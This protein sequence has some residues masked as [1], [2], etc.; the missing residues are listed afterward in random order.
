MSISETRPTIRNCPRCG[1][2]FPCR[3]VGLICDPC[4]AP[5]PRPPSERRLTL[6]ESQISE[7]VAKA[8]ENKEIAYELHLAEGT[9][10]SYLFRI[11]AK[12]NLRNRTELAMFMR[13]R[14]ERQ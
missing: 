7:L 13:E 1:V 9:V 2:D 6:R 5:K 14:A 8:M 10:K 11:Y 4:R 12:F 3:G